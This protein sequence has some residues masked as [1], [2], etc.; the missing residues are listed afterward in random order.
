MAEIVYEAVLDN[1]TPLPPGGQ[2]QSSIIDVNGARTVH[3]MLWITTPDPDVS[4]KLNFGPWPDS[5]FTQTNSGSFQDDNSVAIAVP[6][7]GPSLYLQ[8]ENQGAQDETVV[9]MIYFIRDVP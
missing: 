8:F 1:P 7:F 5:A 9:G 2:V 4:W 6:V 3:L